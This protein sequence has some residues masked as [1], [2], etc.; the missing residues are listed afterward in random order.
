MENRQ[1]QARTGKQRWI[2]GEGKATGK[3]GNNEIER[4]D[5]WG[6]E[7]TVRKTR[8]H[9]P[10][11]ES[12]LPLL[13]FRAWKL[14]QSLKKPSAHWQLW[15]KIWVISPQDDSWPHSS[16][17][18]GKWKYRWR[19]R[20]GW[21]QYYKPGNFSASRYV[22]T[23]V[24]NLFTFSSW[25]LRRRRQWPSGEGERGAILPH[26]ACQGGRR[27][28]KRSKYLRDRKRATGTQ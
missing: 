23:H 13:S 2:V 4:K 19:G 28:G 25:W 12:A 1:L 22:N 24:M 26:V 21:G 16:T 15:L 9:T 8:A 17:L 7:I 11:G 5:N 27:F 10:N 6:L 14:G 20:S 3:G 18:S